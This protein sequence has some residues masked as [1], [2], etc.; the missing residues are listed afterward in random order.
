MSKTNEVEPQNNLKTRKKTLESG[1]KPV[2]GQSAQEKPARMKSSTEKSKPKSGLVAVWFTL[3]VLVV[4]LG[5]GTYFAW[6]WFQ[7]HD[8]S[9]LQSLRQD[10]ESQLSTL[11]ELKVLVESEREARDFLQNDL[12]Q[13]DAALRTEVKRQ[14]LRMEV[15]I[16]TSSDDWYV[17]EAE[18][19][20]RLA[21]R[22]LAMEQSDGVLPLL[23]RA[24]RVLGDIGDSKLVSVRRSL[25]TDIAALKMMSSIDREGLYLRLSALKDIMGQLRI[26]PDPGAALDPEL[27]AETVAGAQGLAS[28]APDEPVLPKAW[29]RLITNAATAFTRFHKE[30]FQVR[31]LDAPLQPLMAPNQEV[32]LRQNLQLMLSQAQLALLERQ[33]GIYRDSLNKSSQW[34]QAFFQLDDQA[35]FLLAE[36]ATLEKEVISVRAPDISASVDSL[37]RYVEYRAKERSSILGDRE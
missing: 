19:L 11:N 33:P 13:A 6:R 21:S 24:D 30:H 35:S 32:Y 1:S 29:E 27:S 16:S 28:D 7:Q 17:A 37:K 25:A 20:L 15:A 14:G 22:R 23:I 2:V 10:R 4:T 31:S 5:A 34:L 26:A 9:V 36:L 3:L 12:T 8:F 18:Y